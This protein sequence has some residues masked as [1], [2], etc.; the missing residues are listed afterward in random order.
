MVSGQQGSQRGQEGGPDS[1]MEASD[2]GRNVDQVTGQ[3]S[4]LAELGGVA[5]E[6]S[7]AEPTVDR[8]TVASGQG[9][10][11]G[12]WG[13]AALGVAAAVGPAGQRRPS[14][15]SVAGPMGHYVGA[16]AGAGSSLRVGTPE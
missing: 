10:A 15:G 6:G 8:A 12:E 14:D 16:G 4:H 9:S 11:P 1:G 3:E 13:P 7:A 5:D 2:D